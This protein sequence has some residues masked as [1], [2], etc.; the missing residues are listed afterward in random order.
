MLAKTAIQKLEQA[1]KLISLDL[2]NAV[3]NDDTLLVETI[4]RQGKLLFCDYYYI[5]FQEETVLG[6]N[7][8][9]MNIYRLPIYSKAMIMGKRF[10][11]RGSLCSEVLSHR[12]HGNSVGTHRKENRLKDNLF[13]R[14]HYSS[15]FQ[16]QFK[17]CENR[18]LQYNDN[19]DDDN[20]NNE[21]TTAVGQFNFFTKVLI[22]DEPLLK[23]VPVASV[24]C[25]S[26][27]NLTINLLEAD[28]YASKLEQNQLQT[29]ILIVD[30]RNFKESLFLDRYKNTLLFIPLYDVYSNPLAVIPVDHTLTPLSYTEI[31]NEFKSIASIL[32]IGLSPERKKLTNLMKIENENN[33][34]STIEEEEEEDDDDEGIAVE[35][36]SD[37]ED[38]D[39]DLSDSSY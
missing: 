7:P 12:K 26:I 18:F 2:N 31:S 27:S 3:T 21:T 4:V 37:D 28:G 33:S 32:L 10:S 5:S 11:A 34:F 8:L 24:T 17:Q 13:N 15:W 23:D 30:C 6:N 9:F 14:D 20:D 35:Y 29:D 36:E 25:R 16:F 1:K 22:D 38:E 19:E 39:G